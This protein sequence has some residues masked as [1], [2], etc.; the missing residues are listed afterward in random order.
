MNNAS[1]EIRPGSIVVFRHPNPDELDHEGKQVRM[2]VLEV[3]GDRAKVEAL[4]DMAI[5][6]CY[7]HSLAELTFPERP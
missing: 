3:N 1:S 7:V 6:P 2:K 5:R 4:V